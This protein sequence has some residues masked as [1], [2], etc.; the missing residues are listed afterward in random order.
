MK[1]SLLKTIEDQFIQLKYRW[2]VFLQLYDSGEANIELLNKSGSNV[3]ALF[4]KLVI[5]DTMSAL[6]R[7]T[8]RANI[9]KNA[10]ASISNLLSLIKEGSADAPYEDINSMFLEVEKH[11]EN[12]R[13][14]RNKAM[15]HSDLSYAM[16]IEPEIR[17]KYDEIEDSIRAIDTL[18]SKITGNS[19]TYAPHIPYG[20]DGNKLL[21]VLA[22]AHEKG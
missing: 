3:F 9:G 20:T 11:M 12:I 2:L 10:N 18:L 7:L 21:S 17:I 15:S 1:A 6:C 16:G 14:Q 19:C 13:K 22:K 4:Q 5:D 8:D